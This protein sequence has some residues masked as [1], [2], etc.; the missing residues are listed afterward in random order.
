[1]ARKKKHTNKENQTELA[2]KTTETA[3]EN[4]VE[5]ASENTLENGAETSN[6]AQNTENEDCKTKEIFVY[7]EIIENNGLKT[8]H[9]VVF[10]LL[11][12][13]RKLAEK[14]SPNLKV[15]AVVC[16]NDNIPNIDD[17]KTELYKGGADK[18]YLVKNDKNVSFCCSSFWPFLI[19]E[20]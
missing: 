15:C 20:S 10:E 13:A 11:C 7:S 4:K 8:F 1:M 14:H 19:L 5:T 2:P 3:P 17:I 6:K 18:I 9:P 16:S 12:A